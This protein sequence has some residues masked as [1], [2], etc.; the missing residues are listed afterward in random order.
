MLFHVDAR[1]PAGSDIQPLLAA[2]VKAVAELRDAGFIE[3]IFRRPDGSGAY[4]V[5]ESDS[6]ATAQATLDWLPFPRAGL[7]TMHITEIERG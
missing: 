4:L 5:V 7:M 2:E 6:A 3:Q 1:I